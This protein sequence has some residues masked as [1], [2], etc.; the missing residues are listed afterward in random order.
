MSRYSF[1]F[2]LLAVCSVAIAKEGSVA[3]VE[4]PGLKVGEKAPNFTLVDQDEKQVK[5][6]DLI[7]KGPVAIVFHRS[8]QW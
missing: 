1:A 4:S 2:L 5:L 8:A 7:K 6:S 3:E